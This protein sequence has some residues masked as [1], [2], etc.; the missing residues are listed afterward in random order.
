MAAP[1]ILFEAGNAGR[2]GRRHPVLLAEPASWP[3]LRGAARWFIEYQRTWEI[4]VG[5]YAPVY[6]RLLERRKRS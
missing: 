4:S 5:R 6:Q 3:A 1:A 2:A